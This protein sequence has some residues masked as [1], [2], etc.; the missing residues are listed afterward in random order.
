MMAP[1]APA[2]AATSTM[3]YNSE[4]FPS[5]APAPDGPSGTIR[6]TPF[7]QGKLTAP[8]YLYVPATSTTPAA[9]YQFIFWNARVGLRRSPTATF[10]AP[11]APTVWDMTAWYLL[12]G[13][14]PCV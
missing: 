8:K 3:I 4:L 13:G 7:G 9:E 6:T 10:V 2:A 11:A 5:G 12:V 1:A 14:G